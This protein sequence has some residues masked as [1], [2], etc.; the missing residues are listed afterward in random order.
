MKPARFRYHRPESIEEAVALLADLGDDAKLLAGGQSLVPLLS[1]R[2]ARVDHL[3]DLNRTAGLSQISMDDGGTTIGAMTRQATV[4]HSAEVAEAVPLLALA[5]PHIGHFQIRNRGTIG[6]SV[7]HADPASELPA[8]ALAL[9]AEIHVVAARGRRSIPASDLFVGTWTT[10]LAADELLQAVRFPA[11]SGRCGFAVEEFARR[12]GDFAIAGAVCA[13]GTNDRS[14]VDR[15]AIVLMGM[16]ATPVRARDAEQLLLG[17]T[18][19]EDVLKEA[20]Q[21]AADAGQPTDDIH[22]PAGYRRRVAAHMVTIAL[23]KALR[24][25]TD[26]GRD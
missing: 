16:G 3:I 23:R 24:Q 9:D 8:V 14:A 15:V 22:G 25:A 11:W 13:V 12:K 20:G 4:E 10:S 17:T 21:R 1:M 19:D 7:A 2:L 6:G 26:H 18:P 5:V